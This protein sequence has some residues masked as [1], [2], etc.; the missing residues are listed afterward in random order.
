[1]ARKNVERRRKLERWEES[2]MRSNT[3]SQVI[4]SFSLIIT[5]KMLKKTSEKWNSFHSNPKILK[6]Y[7]FT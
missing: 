3:Y 7:H 6:I 4:F 5:N 2:L 1:M